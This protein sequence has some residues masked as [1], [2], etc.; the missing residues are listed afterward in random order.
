MDTIKWTKIS[1]TYAEFVNFS[2]FVKSLSDKGLSFA[3]VSNIVYFTF[4]KNCIFSCIFLK[5]NIYYLLYYIY[6]F[7]R[8]N[9]LRNGVQI[10]ELS[11]MTKCL[12][13]WSS[14]SASH[15]HLDASMY[16]LEKQFKKTT[17]VTKK[18]SKP[19]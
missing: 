15:Y 16:R 1:P 9:R 2:K 10:Q 14:K 11:K 5:K 17:S 4:S 18:I 13:W 12:K 6:Y 8:F 3:L 7:L 19:R